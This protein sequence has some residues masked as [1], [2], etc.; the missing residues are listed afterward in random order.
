MLYRD[1]VGVDEAKR[2]LREILERVAEG[3]EITV[4]RHGMPVARLVPLRKQPSAGERA[5]IIEAMIESRHGCTLGELKRR[6]LIA[7]GRK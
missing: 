5:Q 1:F 2:R 4:T 6:E 7:A 3:A